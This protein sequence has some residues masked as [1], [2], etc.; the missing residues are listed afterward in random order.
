MDSSF[1]CGPRVV[2]VSSRPDARAGASASAS[3]RVLIGQRFGP[4]DRVLRSSDFQR[5]YKDGA[6]STTASFAVFALPNGIGRSRL[7]LTVTRKFGTAVVRNRHKRIVREIFRKNRGAFGASCDFVV[8]LRAGAAGRAY[9]ALE[10]EL[11]RA[12]ARLRP[13]AKP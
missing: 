5:I 8:N 6:R 7:G 13:G 1:G 9:G 3:E 2:A 11:I 4:A 12:V 10:A